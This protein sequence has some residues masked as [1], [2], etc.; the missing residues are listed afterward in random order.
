M[1]ASCLGNPGDVEYRGVDTQTGEEIFHQ[2]P[3]PY[4]TNN[5]GEFL[6]IARGLAYLKERGLDWPIYSDSRTAMLWVKNR[7]VR[8]TLTRS[9]KNQE[10]FELIDRALDWLENNEYRNRILKWDT[11]NWGEI[12]ADF[13]RK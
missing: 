2:S 6:A 10:I 5:L 7:Q 8:T 11:T 9:A 1:D 3:L 13:G 12:P 4:G